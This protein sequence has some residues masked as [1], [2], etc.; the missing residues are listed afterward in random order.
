MNP[1]S[2]PPPSRVRLAPL[3]PAQPHEPLVWIQGKDIA[4]ATPRHPLDPSR[5]AAAAAT[6]SPCQGLDQPPAR[7]TRNHHCQDAKQQPPARATHR[8]DPA[9]ATLHAAH[10]ATTAPALQFHTGEPPRRS[11]PSPHRPL[12]RGDRPAPP[13]CTRGRQRPAAADVRRA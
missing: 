7:G 9:R 12:A 6:S 4:T 11:T 13:R 8:P 2:E 10:H 3:V 5:A 1:R